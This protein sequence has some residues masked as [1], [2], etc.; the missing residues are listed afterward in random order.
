LR[1]GGAVG[2]LSRA[3]EVVIEREEVSGLPVN[4]NITER[5]QAGLGPERRRRA[6]PA[7]GAG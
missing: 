5:A 7:G 4:V 3:A 6:E 1:G 2:T